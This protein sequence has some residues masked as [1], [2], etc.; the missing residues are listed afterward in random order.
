MDGRRVK[1][2]GPSPS[3]WCHS[4]RLMRFYCGQV[5]V[6]PCVVRQIVQ[7]LPSPT[8]DLTKVVCPKGFNLCPSFVWPCDITGVVYS[9]NILIL[10]GLFC[11]LRSGCSKKYR[12]IALGGAGTGAKVVTGAVASLCAGYLLVAAIASAAV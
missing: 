11:F 12:G 5:S 7:C 2:S 1:K 6:L 3:H 4:S 9:Y 8:A 10:L